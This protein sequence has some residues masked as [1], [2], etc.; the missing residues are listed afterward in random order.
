MRVAKEFSATQVSSQIIVNTITNINISI[1]KIFK[2]MEIIFYMKYL[3]FW[4]V[5]KDMKMG[6]ILAVELWT[7]QPKLWELIKW[8]LKRKCL[9]LLLN[10][11]NLFLKE[12]HRDQFGEFVC[13][14]WGLKGQPTTKG[15]A[16]GT[17]R[18]NRYNN[19]QTTTTHEVHRAFCTFLR[20]HCTITA[21]NLFTLTF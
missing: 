16:T 19:N 13:G 21:W 17:S 11:L 20:C 14:Y 6:M 1:I 4:A 18:N 12:T 5:D 10:Y 15:T 3:I 9:D 8:P 2:I 7:K